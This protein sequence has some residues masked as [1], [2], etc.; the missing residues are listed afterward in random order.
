MTMP[1]TRSD[2][3]SPVAGSLLSFR[4]TSLSA[5]KSSATVEVW[6]NAG[7]SKVVSVQLYGLR[8][9]ASLG[10]VSLPQLSGTAPAGW[11]LSPASTGDILDVAG[12]A[13]G[14]DLALTGANKL[15]SLNFNVSQASAATG[16]L[17]GFHAQ[18]GQ[19]ELG[20][21][22]P[23]A[24]TQ[25][26]T[27]FSSDVPGPVN[28]FGY[29]FSGSIRYWGNG[30]ALINAYTVKL[31]DGSASSPTASSVAGAFLFSGVESAKPSV[32][33]DKKIESNDTLVKAAINLSDVLDALKLYL[34]KP[35]A[36]PSPYRYFAADLDQNGAVNLSDVLGLLKVYLNKPVAKGPEWDFVDPAALKNVTIDAGHCVL[37]DISVD[38]ANQDTIS[39]V[40]IL[41][42][43]VNGSWSG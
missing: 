8:F 42:G 24:S 20:Y 40:G 31:S 9:D 6:L 27:Y 12:Y 1:L 43:D 38:L 26:S 16:F 34:N 10:S 30:T 28:C 39:L 11:T 13:S 4:N 14:P 5:N 32:L 7:A 19:Y 41:R 22:Q 17:V 33:V 3:Y 2:F 15:F 18:G 36:N 23:D 25:S 35:V 29:G 37:P 21:S